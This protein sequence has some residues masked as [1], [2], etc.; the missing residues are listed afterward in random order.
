MDKIAIVDACL[1]AAYEKS[2]EIVR[3]KEITV[4]V[5]KAGLE[6]HEYE[7]LLEIEQ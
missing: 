4:A 1:A 5:C 7:I 6:I 2:K 3:E